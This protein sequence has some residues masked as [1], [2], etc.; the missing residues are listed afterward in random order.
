MTTTARPLTLEEQSKLWVLMKNL[1][2][3]QTLIAKKNK[4]K[5]PML[6]SKVCRGEYN[7]TPRIKKQ[8]LKA[9]I[10]LDKIMEGGE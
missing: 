6:I 8:F 2:I 3:T 7:V 1:H 9:G 4:L 10:D 5:A